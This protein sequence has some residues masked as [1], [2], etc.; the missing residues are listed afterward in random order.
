MILI[1]GDGASGS[2]YLVWL[3]RELGKTTCP[4]GYEQFYPDLSTGEPVLYE[5]LREKR[6]RNAMTSGEQID[7][8]SVDVIKHLGGFSYDLHSWVDRFQWRV[9]LV[10][11][12]TRGLEEG[13]RR[14]WAQDPGHQPTHKFLQMDHKLFC[15]LN[16]EQIDDRIRKVVRERIGAAVL[17]C[18]DYGY[19]FQVLPFPRFVKDPKFLYEALKPV[20]KQDFGEFYNIYSR[21][22]WQ[23]VK[24]Y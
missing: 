11:I 24:V 13:I 6:I 15:G 23:D 7:W 19:E 21:I 3:L 1:A 12:V 8:N 10:L 16:R 18:I 14:R 20:L 4:K 5:L 9:D 2:S 17:Q 22:T